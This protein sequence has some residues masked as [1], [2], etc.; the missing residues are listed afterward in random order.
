MARIN[1][2]FPGG[3]D[4][5]LT[6]SYDDG[7]QTD[8][9]LIEIM[10]KHGLKGTFN[11]NS[12]MFAP[13]G[14]VYPQGQAQRRMTYNETLEC[15]SD[16]GMEV[17]VHGADHPFWEELPQSVCVHDVIR[18]REQLETM[19]STI[20][21]G[22][23]YPFG[24]YSDATVEALRACGIAYCRTVVSTG[25]FALPS[26]F[27]RWHPTCHHNDSRLMELAKSFVETPRQHH[28]S[29]LFYLWGHSYEFDAWNNWPVIEEFAQYIGGHNHI[30]YATNIE[31]Y[32]YMNAFRALQ[33]SADGKRV[34]NPTLIEV[35]FDNCGKAYSIAP[36]QTVL[37]E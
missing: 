18:D 5:A 10:K 16:S 4:R 24:T 37:L 6:L 30:W 22:A 1:L 29:L 17:A 9:R 2:R 20:I 32:D 11:L 13:E 35:F 23:A 19:F 27:L 26:D 7:V 14:T 8:V 36:G 33:F 25:S 28:K 34:Y 12:D 21:R 31:I 15:F 3:R